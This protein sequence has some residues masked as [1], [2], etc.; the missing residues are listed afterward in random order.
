M[1][2]GTMI[3]LSS[4]FEPVKPNAFPAT[5]LYLKM[6]SLTPSF[7]RNIAAKPPQSQGRIARRAVLRPK[8]EVLEPHLRY[9]RMTLGVWCT[10]DNPIR[11]SET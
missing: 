10:E 4:G 2:L 8:Q 9:F 7:L 6:R 11:Y 3:S 5:P 1:S